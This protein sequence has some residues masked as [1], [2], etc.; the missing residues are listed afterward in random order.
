MSEADFQREGLLDGLEGDDRA[1][2]L[3]LLEEL[4]AAGFSIERLKTACRAP[5]GPV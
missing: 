5:S 1:A 4:T 2:R 3:A